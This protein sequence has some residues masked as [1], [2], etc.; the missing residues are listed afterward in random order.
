VPTDTET[1]AHPLPENRAG[2]V[3]GSVTASGVERD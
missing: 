1:A 2:V 3:H